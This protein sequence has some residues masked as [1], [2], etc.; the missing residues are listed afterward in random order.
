MS[1]SVEELIRIMSEARD[2]KPQQFTSRKV[3]AKGK[4]YILLSRSVEITMRMDGSPQTGLLI[5]GD[6]N[7]LGKSNHA[8]QVLL[9]NKQPKDIRWLYFKNK[10]GAPTWLG[11]I[12]FDSKAGT[13]QLKVLLD[14]EYNK[15]THT[16]TIKQDDR[17][18]F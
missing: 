17:I 18:P 3:T 14:G 15:E 13:N 2:T 16:L 11:H 6:Q 7:P 12:V 4:E 10:S 9:G 8:R 1:L 5:F